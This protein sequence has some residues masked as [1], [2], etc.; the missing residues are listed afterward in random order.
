MLLEKVLNLMQLLQSLNKHPFLKGKWVLKG[1]TALNLFIFN[2][3]RQSVDIDIN[4]IGSVDR[5]QMKADRP[6][7]EQA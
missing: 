7:I 2:L 1:G 4:Y 3:P 6:K 5:D